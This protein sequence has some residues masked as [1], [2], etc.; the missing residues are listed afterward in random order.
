MH[1]HRH[2]EQAAQRLHQN[3]LEVLADPIA[4]KFIS[5]T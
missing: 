4:H 2:A 1:L 5:G 3:G